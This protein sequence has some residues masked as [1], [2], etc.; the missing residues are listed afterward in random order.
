MDVVA[1]GS[2]GT[3]RG[4]CSMGVGARTAVK[5]DSWA[6]R[7]HTLAVIPTSNVLEFI[8]QE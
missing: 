8:V 7:T 4:C 5:T 1:W 6:C 2:E 3:Y